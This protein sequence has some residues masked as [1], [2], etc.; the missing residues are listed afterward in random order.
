MPY[1]G[2][3]GLEL[4]LQVLNCAPQV[5]DLALARLKLLRVGADL[6]PEL[7]TL[8]RQRGEGT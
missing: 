8:P 4:D 7:P 2:Q 6:L 1:R 3:L 5:G